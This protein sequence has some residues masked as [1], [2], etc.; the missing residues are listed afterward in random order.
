MV[1]TV[2]DTIRMDTALTGQ[3]PTS[4]WKVEFTSMEEHNYVPIFTER[5]LDGTLQVYRLM[6]GLN[7]VQYL[8][9]P[10]KLVLTLAQY[11]SLKLLQGRTCYFMGHY[12]DE[13]VPA[14]YR[15]EVLFKAMQEEKPL[16]PMM[17]YFVVDVYL[18]DNAGAAV[19]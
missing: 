2:H 4:E 10:Y 18:E 9:H 6:D 11:E 1:A 16:N 14:T 3:L 7:P 19:G 15:T 17:E 8:D 13:A 12:R 5:A